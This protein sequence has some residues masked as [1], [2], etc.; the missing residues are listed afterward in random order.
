[1]PDGI[2]Y[3][4]THDNSYIRYFRGHKGTVTCLALCPTSTSDTFLSCS[5]D[6]TVKLWDLRSQNA[7]GELRLHGGWLAAYDPSATVIAIASPP[8]SSLLLYDVRNYDKPPFATFDIPTKV[9]TYVSS[10]LPDQ[11]R[12]NLGLAAELKL[13]LL[14]QSTITNHMRSRSDGMSP[15]YVHFVTRYDSGRLGSQRHLGVVAVENGTLLPKEAKGHNDQIALT[16]L[17]ELRRA[18]PRRSDTT[19]IL[20]RWKEYTSGDNWSRA[21]RSGCFRR[22]FETLFIPPRRPQR[23][24]PTRSYA[25]G[26]ESAIFRHWRRLSLARW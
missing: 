22:W 15:Y 21:F 6:D 16:R 9:R 19:R 3:L 26:P 20:Q 18:P 13:S 12:T 4:S 11:R 1:M 10:F 23:P 24:T 7:Q 17:Q 25:D 8:T 2:R 14:S 5:L